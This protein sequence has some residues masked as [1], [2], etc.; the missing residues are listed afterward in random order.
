VDRPGIVLDGIDRAWLLEASRKD[1]VRHAY[2]L[3]DMD[4]EPIR[5]RFV[6][7]RTGRT[8][9]AYLLIWSG[10]PKATIVH[11]VGPGD[12]AAALLS[13]MPPRPIVAVVPEEVGARVRNAL[14]PV[15]AYA[16][17]RLVADPTG[18]APPSPS[19]TVRPVGALDMEQLHAWAGAV[20]SPL[21]N[22]Y[23]TYDPA[24]NAAWAVFEGERIVGASAAGV[25]LPDI[26]VLNGIYVEPAARGRG[27]GMALTAA[28]MAAAR[29]NGARPTLYV[30]EDNRPARRMY[31]RL[32]FRILDRLA[33]IDAG[34]DRPP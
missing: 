5:A 33:W 6:S 8:T 31:D 24:V 34:A 11:W 2:A 18:T 21:A 25:C 19:S 28:A 9:V 3:W 27:Y 1:P 29:A 10:D 15:E 16:V 30:R 12:E 14:A 32:G 13:S 22:A 7:Y 20:E 4:H 17:L 26:W 23:R